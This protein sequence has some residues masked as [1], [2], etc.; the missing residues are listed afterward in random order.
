MATQSK[1]RGVFIAGNWKM[2]NGRE[3]TAAFFS[4]AASSWE[5]A[6]G[7]AT[8]DALRSGS[9]RAAVFPPYLSLEAA[10]REARA[11]ALP[12]DAGA[13]NA[14]WEG[15]GAFTGEVSAGMLME[16]GVKLCLI[17]HS[18]RR[19]L[20]G[21]T[22]EGVRRRTE[23]LLAQGFRVILCVGET[24]AER[25]AGKTHEVLMRQL[26]A[27]FPGDSAPAARKLDGTLV[28]AYEPVWAIGT[29]RNATPEQ[30]EEAHQFIR[31]FLWDGFGMGAS[32][33]TPILYGG[34]VKPDNVDALLACPNVDGALVG[35][36]SV[37][38]S[39]FLAL[40]EAGGRALA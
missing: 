38:P 27:V 11:R 5:K 30:A 10:V 35:G 16:A 32:A 24:L 3:K 8:R 37:K 22:D 15:S 9:L 36:A 13:Q 28:I 14:H 21:E 12:I 26:W 6:L 23:A 40:V 34:S 25:E 39:D 19:T 31:K 1:T 18:E 7:A 17:G 29:G 33:K 4:E 20:F 2:N